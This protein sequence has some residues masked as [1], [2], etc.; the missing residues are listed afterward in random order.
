[1][2][3]FLFLIQYNL[4]FNIRYNFKFKGFTFGSKSFFYYKFH[5]EFIDKNRYVKMEVLDRLLIFYLLVKVGMCLQKIVDNL[6]V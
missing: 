4:I 2:N 3:L 1:M 5:K 6:Y